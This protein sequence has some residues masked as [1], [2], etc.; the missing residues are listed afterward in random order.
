M[1]VKD[2]VPKLYG[3]NSH[4]ATTIQHCMLVLF[5]LSYSEHLMLLHCVSP[6]SSFCAAKDVLHQFQDQFIQGADAKAILFDLKNKNIISDGVET[7]VRQNTDLT[8]QNQL[9]YQHL[10]RVCT[11][12]ALMTV[13]SIMISVPGNP[14]MRKLGDEMKSMLQGECTV[15]SYAHTCLFCVTVWTCDW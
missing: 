13:C 11:E 7:A 8:Q 9:L 14:K 5:L 10:E 3:S 2:I 12:E 1:A 15:C 4:W 6:L